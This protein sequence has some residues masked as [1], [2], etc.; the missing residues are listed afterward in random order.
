MIYQACDKNNGRLHHS[1]ILSLLGLPQLDLSDQAA[2]FTAAEVAMVVKATPS[3]RAPGP[4]GLSGSF[5][6]ATW[7]VIGPDVVRAFR[8]LWDCDFRSFHL[9]NEAI[10]VLIHKTQTPAGLKDY[11]P[12]SLIHSLGK[13]FSKALALRLAPRMHELVSLN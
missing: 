8:A 10:M 3:N 13:L 9:L 5:Y 1:I 7:D 12:I 4:D 2:P 11:R 6:K